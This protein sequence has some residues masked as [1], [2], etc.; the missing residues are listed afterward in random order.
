MIATFNEELTYLEALALFPEATKKY[1]RFGYTEF[2]DGVQ[3]Y[4]WAQFF[5]DEHGV[6]TAYEYDSVNDRKLERAWVPH[7][8]IW[9]FVVEDDET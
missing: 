9:A 1:P 7:Q 5:I 4:L 6:L 2:I 8:R 3:V